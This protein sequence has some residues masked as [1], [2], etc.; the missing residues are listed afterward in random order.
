[1]PNPSPVTDSC[2]AWAGERRGRLGASGIW[3]SHA[4]GPGLMRGL[5]ASEPAPCVL[6]S[7]PCFRVA[8]EAPWTSPASCMF[9]RCPSWRPPALVAA[10]PVVWH[11]QR[12]GLENGSWMSPSCF[13][14]A[15]H[16][17]SDV[18]DTS[19][20]TEHVAKACFVCSFPPV[21]RGYQEIRH[22]SRGPR[23]HCAVLSGV[24][25]RCPFESRCEYRVVPVEKHLQ[26]SEPGCTLQTPRPEFH[27][28]LTSHRVLFFF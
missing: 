2:V 17:R 20:H 11:V 9:E 15:S 18:S 4:R 23:P 10:G 22:D 12:P 25:A 19:D 6:G 27:G 26:A 14:F 13:T 7:R 28:T 16:G 8:F 21:L 1:M 24:A 3:R 5:P